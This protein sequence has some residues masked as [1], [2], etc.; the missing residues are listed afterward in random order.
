MAADP[1]HGVT[2]TFSG[3]NNGLTLLLTNV[4]PLNETREGVETTYHS[5]TGQR[6]FKPEVLTNPGVCEI[7]FHFE[8]DGS[9]P[10]FSTA[11]TVTVTIPIPAES[12]DTMPGTIT[13]TAF[14]TAR[15]IGDMAAGSTETTK[16]TGTFMWDGAT[17]VAFSAQ[18]T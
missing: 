2:I 16:G 9:L 15:T 5:T 4:T 1:Y 8:S 18:D 7:E 17:D 13:G 12:D 14:L 3:A 11:E 6:T 10:S